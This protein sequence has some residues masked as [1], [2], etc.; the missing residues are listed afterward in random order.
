MNAMATTAGLLGL[1][2]MEP[3]AKNATFAALANYVPP[4]NEE[5]SA[6]TL[7]RVITDTEGIFE[8]Y[9]PS[10]RPQDAKV[11]SWAKVNRL[12]GEVKVDVFL[13]PL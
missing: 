7:G 8:L 3:I 6:M 2:E 11:I 12:T 10:D 5:K 13:Q 1:S 9:V 4:S